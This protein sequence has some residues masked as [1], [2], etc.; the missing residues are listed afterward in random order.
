MAF[1]ETMTDP[2]GTNIKADGKF[3]SLSAKG[4]AVANATAGADVSFTETFGSGSVHELIAA[5]DQQP[6][7]LVFTFANGELKGKVAAARTA[8]FPPLLKFIVAHQ[9]KDAVVKDQQSLKDAITAL[10]PGFDNT[11][12]EATFNKI[13]VQTPMGPTS[14]D[15]FSATFNVNGALKD[16]HFEEGFAVEGLSLPPGLVPAWAVSLVPK[17]SSLNV[18][19]KGFDVETPIKAWLAAADFAKD[20][21]VDEATDNALMQSFL[22]K[23]TVE[24][25]INKTVVSNETYA[26]TAEGTF[27]AGPQAMPSGKAHITAKGLDELMK[28]VQSSPPEAGLQA[29]A[30]MIIAAKGLGKAGNDGTFT[31]DV[32]ATP[33]GKIL[34]NGT[35][36][37][38]IGQQ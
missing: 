34:V 8:A 26:F 10:L 17:L 7:D 36:V 4:T 25:S 29:A 35:D 21:P 22:P 30:G 11:T 33:D 13:E 24:V 6:L 14:L 16:G 20:P 18:A 28:V 19:V 9:T 15:K 31:Y 27:T 5:Q 23:G 38:K 1:T 3:D 12:G 37:N 32:D 2:N